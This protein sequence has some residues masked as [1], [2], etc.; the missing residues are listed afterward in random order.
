MAEAWWSEFRERDGK[1]G[2]MNVKFRSLFRGSIAR[3]FNRMFQSPD[4]VLTLEPPLFPS[5]GY[6][7]LP[8][9][10]RKVEMDERDVVFFDATWRL[11]LRAANFAEIVFKL[12]IRTCE[13]LTL[14]TR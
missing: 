10:N 13:T 3:V 11:A 8:N 6:A 4:D 2:A 1:A 12:G 14:K 5:V 7:W 9:P